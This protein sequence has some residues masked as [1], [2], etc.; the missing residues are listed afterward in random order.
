MK[1]VSK[2]ENVE[3]YEK[4]YLEQQKTKAYKDMFSLECYRAIEIYERYLN[5]EDS[6]FSL[7]E[8]EQD[9][10]EFNTLKD[11]M[12]QFEFKEV[13]DRYNQ[14][15][16]VKGN[17]FVGARSLKDIRHLLGTGVYKTSKG[18]YLLVN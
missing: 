14:K 12:E 10:T 17:F 16:Y 13:V 9:Y 18:T 2:I 7:Q 3:N 11:L 5:K 4:K 8:V 6:I 1:R 15:A